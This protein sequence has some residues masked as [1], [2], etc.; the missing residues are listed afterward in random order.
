MIYFL[1][2]KES[3]PSFVWDKISPYGTWF[4]STTS[5]FNNDG[6]YHIILKKWKKFEDTEEDSQDLS[7]DLI[8][9]IIRTAPIDIDNIS[10]IDDEEEI[11]FRKNI[12]CRCLK[13]EDFNYLVEEGEWKN[14]LR[15]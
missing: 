12:H 9:S 6:S 8:R 11:F 13:E 10:F 15:I 7:C 2:I 5:L 3:M 14:E 4:Q 1:Y